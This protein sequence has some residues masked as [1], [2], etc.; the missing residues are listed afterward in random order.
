MA[1]GCILSSFHPFCLSFAYCVSS[2]A[3]ER[4]FGLR[5]HVMLSGG[6][7]LCGMSW[8]QSKHACALWADRSVWVKNEA[9]AEAEAGG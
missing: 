1:L 6:C 5:V 3:C 8:I 9:D 2:A 4:G 7:M